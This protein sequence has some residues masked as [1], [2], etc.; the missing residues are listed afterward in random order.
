VTAE[1]NSRRWTNPRGSVEPDEDPR[2]AAARERIL[3]IAIEVLSENGFNGISLSTV[4]KR[5]G[6][7]RS[8]LLHHFESKEVLLREAL[9]HRLLSNAKALHSPETATAFEMLDAVVRMVEFTVWIESASR[10]HLILAAEATAPE[11]PAHL[12]F[13]E[14]FALVR[15]NMAGALRRSIAAGEVRPDVDVEAIAF[16]LVSMSD[17]FQLHWLHSPGS[18]PLASAKYVVELIKRDIRADS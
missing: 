10:A 3:T 14:Q 13:R 16:L 7:T 11:H 15:D 6:F 2:T 18:D 9:G 1:P 4:A 5:A 12:W 17:G 8:G